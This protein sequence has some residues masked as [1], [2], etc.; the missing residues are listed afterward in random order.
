M[1]DGGP[2]VS[3]GQRARERAHARA[4][5]QGGVG[6]AEQRGVDRREQPRQGRL[7]ARATPTRPVT[8]SRRM[9]S[10]DSRR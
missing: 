5:V 2:E 8:S 6:G 4:A 9:P 7:G 1:P 10:G 3:A